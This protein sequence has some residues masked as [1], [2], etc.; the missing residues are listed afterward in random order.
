LLRAREGVAFGGTGGRDAGVSCPIFRTLYRAFPAKQLS[1]PWIVRD[2]EMSRKMILIV[3]PDRD[4]SELFAR[5]LETHRDCKCY[6]A[7]SERDALDLLKEFTFDVILADM[8]AVMA[9]D[10]S[11]LRKFRRIAPTT[12]VVVDAYLH[13][14]RHISRALSLGAEDYV[15]KPITVEVFR[16]KMD[17]LCFAVA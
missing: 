14:K 4:V 7:S 9:E 5:A 16:K 8:D 12:M 13:Q 17:A 10:Y 15:I 2:S 11:L 1:R 3:E 6:L